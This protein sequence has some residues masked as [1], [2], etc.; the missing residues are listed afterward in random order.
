MKTLFGKLFLSFILIIVLIIAAVLISFTLVY[1]R[2]YEEQLVEE[3]R[4]NARYVALSL[5]SFLHTAYKLVEDLSYN[6]DVLSMNTENQTRIFVETAERNDFFELLY[7]Q[8]MD[9]MQTGR[10]RGELANRGDRWWFIHMTE[11]KTPYITETYISVGTDMACTSIY[12]PMWDGDEMIGI[13]AADI[14]LSSIHDLI[15]DNSDEYSYSFI[16][17]GLG[18]VVAHPDQTFVDELYN[19]STFTKTVLIRDDE[20][21]PIKD[22][23]GY[24]TEE[25]PFLISDAYKA[26]I[27]HMMSGHS[28]W[29]KFRENRKL[30]YLTYLPVEIDGNSEPWYVVTIMDGDKA[31]QT[32]N[33]VIL[34]ILISAVIISLI[35]L[36]IVYLVS[37]NISS[38]IKN[39]YSIL[40]KIKNGD[41]SS[42]ISIH[43][44]DEIGEMM[45]ML[46]QTQEGIK[47][48]INNIETEAAA[49]I[50][51]DAESK[52]KTSF[53]A[54]VSHEIR[55][56]M[57]T[58]SGMTEMI[59]RTELSDQTRSYVQDIK[60]A[61]NDLV[62]IINDI[63]DFSKV[64]AGKLEIVS[65]RY[66]FSSLINDTVNIIRIR[67]SDKN[68]MFNV[69]V[70]G[71][72][73]NNLIGD[74]V[75][76]RQILLNLLS[77][78]VKYTDS[79]NISLSVT[80]I[81]REG[82]KI[83]LK[84]AV[85]DTGRGIKSEDQAL[86][87]GDFIRVDKKQNIGVD[88]IGLG[89]AIVK[90]LVIA[91][92]GDINVESE[93]GSGST[94]SVVVPQI[95]E[96][97]ELY[98]ETH[99]HAK[100]AD[101]SHIISFIIPQVKI[102]IVDDIPTNLKVAEGLLSPYKVKIDICQSGM[103]ALEFVKKADYD[104]IFMDHMMP[105]MDGIETIAHI[106][107]WEKEQKRINTP[108]IAL[109][110]NAV[111]GMREMFLDCGFNDFLA[112][113]I[114]II[115]MDE[116]LDR[117][118]PDEKKISGTGNEKTNKEE[119][120]LLSLLFIP[121]VDTEKGIYRT[122]GTV[123][124]YTA[125]LSMFRTDAE[126]RMQMFQAV[127]TAETL[128]S[129]TTQAH[130]FKSAFAYI[131]AEDMSGKAA[132]LEAAGK[133][134]D[135]SLIGEKL[136]DFSKELDELIV[137]VNN[138]LKLYNEKVSD[139]SC[140][141]LSARFLTL[142]N[143]LKDAFTA[144]KASSDIFNI[145][146]EINKISVNPEYRDIFERISFFT[147]MNEYEDALKTLSALI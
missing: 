12:F 76:L 118:I 59:L 48:L 31:M 70:D 73:P 14:R 100:T 103:E 78:A 40:Q 30:L 91:M 95:V 7:A 20:G 119:Q 89:L 61:G 144:N 15:L 141:D 129:F 19:Y 142:I 133:A 29:T 49:R 47:N 50:K 137:N 56:P 38:P 72:I 3:N 143:E 106:R 60:H 5:R 4:Q 140:T 9:G 35:T 85:S 55:T 134:G 6:T 27:K 79:G 26:P 80:L 99:E 98:S 58:I 8:G 147:L 102:L 112:K 121:G 113:P 54:K 86:L 97:E 101:S 41:L 94:F 77:N 87:F 17:D 34:L 93:Y 132:K 10:S 124:N 39:V 63:L 23:A 52:S 123:E 25:V 75:R 68:L 53:L 131:G 135:Y 130:A 136:N 84:M 45:G 92:D 36:I 96:S 126:E 109:T 28:G 114:D 110:A 90:Q 42:K 111:V 82:Q 128:S 2:S 21:N 51:A 13:M 115:R 37:R 127:P 32:R 46:D 116:I 11:T 104:L 67:I 107:T 108:V 22:S 105:E 139:E 138:A 125:V 16:I 33:T 24:D 120:S 44:H 145:L 146:N 62:S 18:V 1:S 71:N 122:G 57:N 64:E 83:W 69:D 65:A 66:M 43:S 81:K 74:H 117:W 88:G